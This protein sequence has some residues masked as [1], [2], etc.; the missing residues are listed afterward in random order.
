MAVYADTSY[1]VSLYTIDVHTAAALAHD[2]QASSAPLLIGF[3]RF[4]LQN[5]IR[6]KVFRREITIQQAEAS[7][8]DL[9]RDIG[10]GAIVLAHCDW[11]V[12]LTHGR[13]LSEHFTV[14]SGHRGMDV[15]HVASAVSLGAREFLTFDQ[16][17]AELARQAGLIVGPQ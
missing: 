17:Q 13:L 6:L 10:S 12:V 14:Q 4:E 8:A 5:A 9:D 7:L 11:E 16:R 2:E 3:G 15:L 1:L